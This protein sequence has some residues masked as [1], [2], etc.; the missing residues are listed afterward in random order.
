[1]DLHVGPEA[2]GHFCSIAADTGKAQ[3][4][5]PHRRHGGVHLL[6]AKTSS[7]RQRPKL[8]PEATSIN[9]LLIASD[10]DVI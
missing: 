8:R 6:F 5:P 7:T 2:V 3:L 9:R 4:G 10:L 1:M